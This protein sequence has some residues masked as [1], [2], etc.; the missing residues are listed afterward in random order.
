MSGLA[1]GLSDM[2][3]LQ[4]QGPLIIATRYASGGDERRDALWRAHACMHS[5]IG[6]C[7]T[8]RLVGSREPRSDVMGEGGW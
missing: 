1:L 8:E 2:L 5:K 4:L 7:R 3:Q 6:A